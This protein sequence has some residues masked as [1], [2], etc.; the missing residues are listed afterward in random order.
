MIMSH[1]TIDD[2]ILIQEHLDNKESIRSIAKLLSKAPSTILRE[3]K[4]HRCFRGRKSQRTNL[5]P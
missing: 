4:N 5:N 1:L 2:R 3:I